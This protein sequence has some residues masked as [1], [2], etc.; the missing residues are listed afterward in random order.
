MIRY[1]PILIFISIYGSRRVFVEIGTRMFYVCRAFL[2]IGKHQC[3]RSEADKN[4]EQQWIQLLPVAS[5][6]ERAVYDG[7]AAFYFVEQFCLPEFVLKAFG[8]VDFLRLRWQLCEM[9]AGYSMMEIRECS[10]CVIKTVGRLYHC[11]TAGDTL[12]P[13]YIAKLNLDGI[14]YTVYLPFRICCS[15]RLE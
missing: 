10:V 7:Y 15:F 6:E 2:Q 3:L 12:S 1:S 9:N 13:I 14:A 11:V 4:K 8:N 5:R